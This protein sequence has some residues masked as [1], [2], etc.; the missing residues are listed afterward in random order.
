MSLYVPPGAPDEREFLIHEGRLDP[1]PELV[2]A[3]AAAT[4]HREFGSAPTPAGE[5]MRL[6][7]RSGDGVLHR[8]SL[9]A[10]LP[11]PE[12]D[13]LG[14][15]RRRAA[16]ERALADPTV[17]IGVRFERPPA[18][19]GLTDP[20]LQNEFLG[21]FAA[22]AAHVRSVSRSPLDP[23]TGL[24]ERSE[25]QIELGAAFARAKETGLPFVLLLLGPEDFGWVNERLHRRSGDRA[26]R[27][28]ATVLRSA[29]RSRDHVARYGGA[30]FTVILL[31]TPVEGARLVA[32]NVVQRL[33]DHRY[34]GGT[35]R[36]EFSAGVAAADPAESLD[37]HEVVR[38]ADQALGAA[39]RGQAHS[40]C[41]WEKGSDVETAGSVDRLQG[42]FTGDRSKDYRNMGLLLDQMAVVAGSTDR[43][44]LAR[45]FSLRLFE[46]LRARRVGVL[47]RSANGFDLLGGVARSNAGS[48]AFEVEGR[49]RALVERT[50]L[51]RRIVV[52]DGREPGALS[53]CAL[54]LVLEDRCLG[55]ILLEVTSVNVSFEASDRRFLN[56]LASQMAVALD[57]ARLAELERRRQCEERERLEAEVE[58]LR[59]VVKGS[60]LAFRSAEMESV[61]FAV[62]KVAGTD[63]TVLITGESGTGKEMLAHT[64][65][66]LSRRQ[67]RPLVVVDCSAISPSLIESDL[68]GHERGAFT[69]AHARKLG[70]LVQADGATVFLDEIGDIPLDL[71]SKL[72][73][74]VQEKQLTPV[75]GVQPRRVDVRIIAATNVDL[76]ARVAEGRFREDLFHR[77]NVVRL[78]LPPL[79]ERKPDILHLAS[80]FLQQF[81]ALYRRPA[82]HFT[83]RAEEA[84]LA[85]AWPGNVRELQNAVLTTVLFHDARE[86]D[87][88]DLHGLDTEARET[89]G[90]AS[91]PVPRSVAAPPEAPAQCP[92]DSAASSPPALRLRHA[93]AAEVAAA[94]VSGRQKA[95]PI[96]RWLA[97]DLILAADRLAGGTSRRGSHLLGLPDS[98]YRRQL[99]SAASRRANGITTRSPTWPAVTSV[100]DDFIRA[101]SG[102]TDACQWAEACLL[103]ELE[104]AA[105]G[106]ARSAAALLGVTEPT[107]LRRKAELARRF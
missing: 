31:D 35:L 61:L 55:G 97:E 98:T 69:G 90:A 30:M 27:E 6:P 24:P 40:V 84:L 89:V 107:F 103:V 4:L 64:V 63:A 93:L 65:H 42:I 76:R 77:L 96:G 58:D 75:G 28:I 87:A 7:S 38:R 34:H 3:G 86:V 9:S 37:A 88:E 20:H 85:Y 102:E 36:L 72:L 39:R 66:E 17:W 83:A 79:R 78:E 22:F 44:E 32:E 2:D 91:V 95:V 43:A 21:L 49:D 80:L 18:V 16:S 71:Q 48:R 5:V 56:A 106:D 29:V 101:R 47:E 15:E 60:R 57:R 45:S 94:L 82:Q 81:S 73:R 70:R 59:R 104:S 52:E 67:E 46:A 33:G 105:P 100:L 23:V 19:D 53:L 12:N 10:S 54:P 51:E 50:M 25:F 68:F 11:P 13:A 99:H 8:I 62:R 26:L 92:G 1:L 41:V 74:F 14:R